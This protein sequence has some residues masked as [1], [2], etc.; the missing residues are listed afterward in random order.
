M[1]IY[2]CKLNAKYFN[3]RNQGPFCVLKVNVEFNMGK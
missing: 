1:I 2:C 3:F